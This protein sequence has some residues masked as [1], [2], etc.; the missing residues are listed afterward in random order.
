VVED[1]KNLL[2]AKNGLATS[3]VVD[4]FWGRLN[5]LGENGLAPESMDDTYS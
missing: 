1:I 3:D 4:L 5:A 2:S